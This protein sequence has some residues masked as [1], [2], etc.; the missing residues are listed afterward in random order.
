MNARRLRRRLR[1]DARARARRDGRG[2][3]LADAGRARSL[4][5][6]TPTS[7]TG[8]WS[9]QAELRL[10]PRRSGRDQ[11]ARSRELNAR[12]KAAQPTNRRTFGSVFKN[13]RA[14]A[15]R[16]PDARGVRPQG[17]PHRRRRRSRPSTRTSSRTPAA[18]RARTRVA[19]MAEARRRAHEQYGVELQPRGRAPRTA[20]A[21]RARVG[22]SAP[23][24]KLCPWQVSVEARRLGRC[25]RARRPSRCRRRG[26]GWRATASPGMR[27]LGA[28]SSSVSDSSR[29]LPAPYLAVRETSTFAIGR[30]EVAGAPP[31][32]R[33][34]VRRRS[35][36]SRDE[37]A[38]PRRRDALERRV[39]A[40]P[41]VV[42]VDYDRALPAHAPG[43]R[44]ARAAGRRPPPRRRETWLVS[45]RGRVVAASRT[46]PTARS[47][48]SGCRARPRSRPARSS[49]RTRRGGDRPGA[50]RV[51]SRFPA[52]DR[53]RV[54]R[55]TTSSSSCSRSGIELRLGA[56]TDVRLKLAI[57]RRASAL[58]PR[59]LGLPRRQRRPDAPCRRS[60][61]PSSL[62]WR[63]RL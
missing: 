61:Q 16:G 15:D 31:D 59:R 23:A 6:A 14:R 11:G 56:P 50:R 28:P 37:P 25:V 48:A 40:L 27:P 39:E 7:A 24:A 43:H 35:R 53:R 17:P 62:K 57:A 18:R 54:A 63:L 10:H 8:R 55:P 60:R 46:S 12:R 13:P 29:S 4:A 44:L 58:L 51:A 47:R 22:A 42:S 36:R 5:T 26:R 45:A 49:Y 2:N 20:R 30:V 41:T 38:R 19:L 1:A 33:A 3:R 9:S 21:A 52:R 34:Q 32:V